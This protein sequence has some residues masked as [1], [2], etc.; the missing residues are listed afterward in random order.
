MN[1]VVLEFK[2]PKTKTL[3]Y[4]SVSIEVKPYIDISEQV[5][6]IQR[7]VE[8]YFNTAKE[9]VPFIYQA[10]S[11]YI[12][13][14]YNLMHG[15]IELLTNVDVNSVNTD[16]YD[17]GG[18]WKDVR[19]LIK[20]Y[21]EFRER[22][23]R[24]VADIKA[25]RQAQDSLGAVVRQVSEKALA[26]LSNFSNITPEQLEQAKTTSLELLGKMESSSVLA[27]IKDEAP[28]IK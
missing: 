18:F 4:G 12:R 27:K 7:Y 11:D 17:A 25:E 15:I 8:T 21:P 16:V 14:E 2:A 23:D 6:L 13:A 1:K 28:E 3:E 26:V 24:V 22:L 20:N 19:N 5:T 10:D 9:F